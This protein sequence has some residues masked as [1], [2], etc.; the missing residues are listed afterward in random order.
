MTATAIYSIANAQ[1]IA[2]QVVESSCKDG[3]ARMMIANVGTAHIDSIQAHFEGAIVM[4]RKPLAI[5]G[6]NLMSQPCPCSGPLVKLVLFVGA[7]TVNKE[8]F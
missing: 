4:M 7:V 3:K 1:T 8:D 5:E 2:V 6:M